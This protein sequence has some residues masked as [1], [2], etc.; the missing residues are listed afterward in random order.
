VGFS[1]RRRTVNISLKLTDEI[2]LRVR[3][4]FESSDD[5]DDNQLTRDNLDAN[6]NSKTKHPRKL[7]IF[8]GKGVTEDAAQLEERT[9][10]LPASD[11]R[12]F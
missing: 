7:H 1:Q 10:I 8:T 11:T 2:R 6:D 3:K 9:S 4:I 12:F 5:E